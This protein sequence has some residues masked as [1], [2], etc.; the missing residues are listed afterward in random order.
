MEY[1]TL[2]AEI[3][4][5]SNYRNQTLVIASGAAALVAGFA[6]KDHVVPTWLVVLMAVLLLALGVGAWFDAGFSI[7]RASA[8]VAKIEDEINRGFHPDTDGKPE[9]L[10]WELSF[11]E[12]R[13]FLGRLS[14]GRGWDP[15]RHR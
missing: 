15:R 8:R 9:I 4:Q 7:G 6:P 1:A 3:M 2:R 14:Q 5:R 10:A 11:Q 12:N 13:S